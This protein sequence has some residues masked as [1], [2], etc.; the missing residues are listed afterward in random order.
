MLPISESVPWTWCGVPRRTFVSTW[1][2]DELVTMP[3]SP[4]H[5]LLFSEWTALDPWV[6]GISR[7]NRSR[8]KH[9]WKLRTRNRGCTESGWNCWPLSVGLEAL[10]Q[11]SRVTLVT[12]SRYVSRGLRF[13]LEEWRSNGWRWERDGRP[14]PIKN[15]DLWQRVDWAL[16]FHRVRCRSWRIDAAECFAGG[17][18]AVVERR[19]SPSRSLLG[20]R[21]A[22]RRATVVGNADPVAGQSERLDRPRANS[23]G[24]AIALI[25]I[26]HVQKN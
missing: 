25:A 2:G 3:N 4:P 14:V 8:A 5:F 13:G 23:F 21:L 9:W 24:M 10:E 6:A 11:P 7:S 18:P 12:S 17:E 1:S 19:P 16:K 22:S 20:Q 26:G 15:G